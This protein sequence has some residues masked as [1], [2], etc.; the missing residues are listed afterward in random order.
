LHPDGFGATIRAMNSKKIISQALLA[1]CAFGT[2]AGMRANAQAKPESTSQKVLALEQ[3]WNDAYKHSDVATMDSLL[4]NDFII[5]VEDGATYSKPGYIAHCS[6][7]NV[8]VAVAEISDVK[9]RMHGNAAVITGSYHEKGTNKGEAYEL[10]DRFTDVWQ[11]NGGKWQLIA[12]HYA[13]PQK[14]IAP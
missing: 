10:H 1:V 2:F 12:S 6:D 8:K 4:T 13:V 3:K 5:T 11:E 9:A 14:T 7:P